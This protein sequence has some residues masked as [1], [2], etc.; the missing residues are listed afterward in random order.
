M[1]KKKNEERFQPK[2]PGP[3]EKEGNPAKSQNED[4]F[5]KGGKS[6]K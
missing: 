5:Q 2:T 4:I 6:K 1:G 3:G